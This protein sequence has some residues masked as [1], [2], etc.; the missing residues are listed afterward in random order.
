MI[1]LLPPALISP[2][3]GATTTGASDPPVGLPALRWAPVEKATR[4]HVQISASAGFATLLV[5]SD[6]YATA[7]SPATALADGMYY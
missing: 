1:L 4:Y 2:L 6:T 5:D 3:D 7:Y